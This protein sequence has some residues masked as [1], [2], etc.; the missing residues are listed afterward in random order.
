MDEDVLRSEEFERITE[1][2][3]KQE[4]GEL[5]TIPAEKVWEELDVQ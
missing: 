3:R 2:N 1:I 5:E 4:E